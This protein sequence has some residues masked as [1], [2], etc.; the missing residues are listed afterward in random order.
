[1]SKLIKSN[2]VK[3]GDE[4][5]IIPSAITIPT[6]DYLGMHPTG[7]PSRV[8]GG[9]SSE[10][11][12][13]GHFEE[14]D[15]SNAHY[16]GHPEDLQALTPEAQVQHMLE[17][18]QREADGILENARESAV[19][20]EA[21]SLDQV[22]TLYERTYQEAYDA[23]REAGYQ[24]GR[25]ETHAEL[26][27][28]VSLKEHWHQRLEG[29][30]PEL[31]GEAVRLVLSCLEKVLGEV[32]TTP[33]Y[34]ASLLRVGFESIAYAESV[35]VRICERDF[36]YATTLREKALAMTDSID[37]IQFKVD[38]ALEPGQVVIETSR[39]SVDVS[40]QGQL[41]KIRQLFENM[42][43]SEAYA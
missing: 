16:A 20:I 28:A 38:Y 31:E 14:M 40:L 39:G 7:M 29:L 25:A 18:A 17:A 10:D 8:S 27:E 5:L 22:K 37:D 34:V 35:E 26:V 42:L 21:E 13:A 2:Q 4:K 6:E 33:D 24:E 12:E 23:G 30:L 36:D 15:W 41:E 19:A 3:I 11:E 32:A 1:M 43:E 9:Y